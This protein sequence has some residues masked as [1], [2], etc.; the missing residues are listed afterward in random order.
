VNLSWQAW[1]WEKS[2]FCASGACVEVTTHAGDVYIRDSKDASLAPL[3][4]TTDEWN[5]FIKGVHAGQFME[6][7]PSGVSV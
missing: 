5:A 1:D 6:I 4:F 7:Q 3:R 2:T